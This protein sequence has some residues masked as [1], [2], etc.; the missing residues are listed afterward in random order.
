MQGTLPPLLGESL[1]VRL[2]YLPA[3]VDALH[4]TGHL[5][6]ELAVVA[7]AVAVLR[8]GVLYARGVLQVLW[9]R[10]ETNAALVAPFCDQPGGLARPA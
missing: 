1:V 6:D 8:Q 5:L 10:N 9:K 3:K 2:G 4:V 7:A